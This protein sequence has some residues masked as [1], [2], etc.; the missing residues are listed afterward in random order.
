MNYT[1]LTEQ[2][3]SYAN[4]TDALFNA[5]IPNFI[6]QGIN[7]I[8][9][10]AKNIGFEVTKIGDI[11][12]SNTTIDK[13][14]NW[15]ET[16]SLEIYTEDQTFSKFLFNRSYE[17]CK[18]Y[19]PNQTL[20]AEPSFYADYKDYE[21][22]FFSPT[23]DKAYK[24]RLIYLGIPLFNVQNGENF[25]TRR[26]PRLLFYA[27][28]LEAMPFLKD[29]ERLGQFEQL[30]ASSLDDINKDSTARYVDRISDRGKE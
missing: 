12:M 18:S 2:I 15:R 7:R 26:Y 28:M 22:F 10:E 6:E 19:W 24:Y 20:T 13:P 30:Y 11:A 3:K 1:T 8:Y 4:R 17:F 16:I 25:L 29:D 21:K 23:A 5:Q 14:A 9:S 27:C